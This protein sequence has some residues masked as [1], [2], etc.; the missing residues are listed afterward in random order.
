MEKT[1][2]KYETLFIVDVTKGDENVTEVV[3]RFKSL[4]AENG[5]VDELTEWG[6]RKLAYPINDMT[7]GYYEIIDFTAAPEFIAELDRLLGL[8]ESVMR[9]MTIRK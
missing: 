6:K 5:T 7:E 3:E 2:N 8:N 9:Y 1:L 4:I